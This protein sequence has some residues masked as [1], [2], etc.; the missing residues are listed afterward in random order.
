MAWTL[1]R[2]GLPDESPTRAAEPKLR[3]DGTVTPRRGTDAWI[4]SGGLVRTLEQAGLVEQLLTAGLAPAVVYGWG[5]ATCN[6]VLAC[7]GDARALR[8]G[9][10]ELRARRFVAVAALRRIP[11]LRAL[12]HEQRVGPALHARLENTQPGVRL[13]LHVEGRF[14]PIGD[15]TLASVL[16]AATRDDSRQPATL[17]TAITT[18]VTDSVERIL[19]LGRHEREGSVED[20]SSAVAAARSAGVEVCFVPPVGDADS[21]DAPLIDLL[22]PGSGRVERLFEAGRR[23]A[24]RWTASRQAVKT[25]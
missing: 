15:G 6:A 8:R 12:T 4:L 5:L 23:A 25:A 24:V 14:L 22:L 2:A 18:A 10:E 21:E 20:L 16:D 1:L 17:A 11:W 3:P 7:T 9:W 19:V 13:L